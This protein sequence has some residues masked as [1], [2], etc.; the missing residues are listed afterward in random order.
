[1]KTVLIYTTMHGTTEKVSQ[2]IAEHI[3]DVTLVK[4]S[5]SSDILISSF[6]RVILGGSIHMGS[7]QSSV[8]K[9]CTRHRHELLSKPVALFVCGMEKEPGKQKEELRLAFP[10]GI[11]T[12]ALAKAF[13]GGEFIFEKMNFIQRM[14]IK[15][16]A[17]TDRSLSEIDYDVLN[18]FIS[19]IEL[20]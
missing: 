10:E 15:K 4:I 1:M 18:S 2:Y 9:F 19:E 5:N 6:D 12:H 11:N 7:I 14:M 3:A 13:V 16:I 8:K 17:H 20:I